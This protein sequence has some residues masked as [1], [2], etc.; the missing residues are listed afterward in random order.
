MVDKEELLDAVT[1]LS[2]S[3]PAYAFTFLEA[4]AD[5]GVL[6]GLPRPLARAL[7]CQ[8]L[9]GTAALAKQ[10]EEHPAELR[11]RVTS[12]GG[13]TAAGLRELGAHGFSNAVVE[14]VRAATLRSKELGG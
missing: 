9:F 7:A 8:T 13:T 5:G 4:M 6:M 2:G 1:G 12:P 10:A 11:D 14:A 3:G